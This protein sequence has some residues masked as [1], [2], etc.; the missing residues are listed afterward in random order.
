MHDPI[1]E[2]EVLYKHVNFCG[3]DRPCERPMIEEENYCKQHKHER[4]ITWVRDLNEIARELCDLYPFTCELCGIKGHFTFH[5]MYFQN[6]TVN[7]LCDNMITSDLYDEL[8]LFLM[9]EE[10]SEKT[11]WLDDNALG[12]NNTLQNCHLYCVVNCHENDYISKIRKEGTL[13]KYK[14][15]SYVSTNKKG[16]FAQVSPIVYNDKPG[17]VEKLS[18]QPLLPKVKKKKKKRRRKRSKKEEEWVTT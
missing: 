12:I 5:C 10:L 16:S 9:Y 11:S 4:T 17:N 18:L 15:V 3:V 13:P 6:I 7:Q 2:N 14:N 1:T 8:M